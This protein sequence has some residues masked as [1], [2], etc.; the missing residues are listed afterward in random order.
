MLLQATLVCKP[1]EV[2]FEQGNAWKAKVL[3]LRFP[4]FPPPF[5]AYFPFNFHSFI[6]VFWGLFLFCGVVA[7]CGHVYYRAVLL[8]FVWR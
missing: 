1:D 6:L 4:P 2:P 7:G 5:S 3:G 8:M